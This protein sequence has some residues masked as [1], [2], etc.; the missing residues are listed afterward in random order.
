MAAKPTLSPAD[1]D[2]LLLLA[3][4]GREWAD[5]IADGGYATPTLWLS[6][7]WNALQADGW[8]APGY[9]RNIDGAWFQM[10][11]GGLRPEDYAAGEGE[12]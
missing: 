5:F 2:A 9:W 12:P 3:D 10:T 6:D 7:G 1:V 4:D 8:E 11:L